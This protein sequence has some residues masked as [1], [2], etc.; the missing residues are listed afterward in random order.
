MREEQEEQED[1]ETI[2]LASGVVFS[3]FSS[4]IVRAL[5][6]RRE[7][8]EKE[9]ESQILNSVL[10]ESMETL[11][12]S[13]F[14]K[15]SRIHLAIEPTS[16]EA[17]STPAECSICL[18]EIQVGGSIIRLPCGDIFHESCLATIAAHQHSACPLCRQSI[19]T[20]RV[21][22]EDGQEATPSAR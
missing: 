18:E 4:F 8:E 22:E 20:I 1:E 3:S 21:A 7:E 11:H 2:A 17:S 19:P 14:R 6:R 13:L 10:N 9:I 12:G 16:M 5:L 15:D